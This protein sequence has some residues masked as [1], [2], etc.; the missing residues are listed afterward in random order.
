LYAKI[1]AIS[2]RA[3]TA[4]LRMAFMEAELGDQAQARIA[5]ARAVALD[6]GLGKYR[7]PATRR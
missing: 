7:L 6:P 4:Y 5:D 2:P 1:I 3:S